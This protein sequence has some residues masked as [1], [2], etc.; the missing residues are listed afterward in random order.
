LELAVDL[1]NGHLV[2]VNQ[3]IGVLNRSYPL[4]VLDFSVDH[5]GLERFTVYMADVAP[6]EWEAI[7]K[8]ELALPRGWS[9]ESLIEIR[10]TETD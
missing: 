3:S 9:L 10:R 4:E 5:E 7:T 2:E 6:F 1:R 8:R